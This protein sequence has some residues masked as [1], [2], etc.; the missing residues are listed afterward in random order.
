MRGMVT[1]CTADDGADLQVQG[2]ITKPGLK[3]PSLYKVIM[4]NDD[5]TPMDF[6]VTVL[7]TFFNMEKAIATNVMYEVHSRGRATCGTFSKD[8]AE[9]KVD[10]VTAYARRHEYPLLCSIEAT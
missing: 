7:E 1:I 8:I 6:V 2:T 5:F 3:E 9:T 4:H 10:Q